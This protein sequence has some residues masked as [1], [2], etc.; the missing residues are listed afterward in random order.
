MRLYVA[1][2]GTGNSSNKIVRNLKGD[3]LF[4]TNSFDGLKRDIEGESGIYDTVYMFGLD[5]NLKGRIR[6]EQCATKNNIS[7]SSELDIEKL[8]VNLNKSG[9]AAEMGNT[10]KESL[11]NTA[12][13]YMLN[14]YYNKVAF[15][16]VPSIKYINEDF[17]SKIKLTL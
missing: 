7:I 17:I 16:H 13:W 2:K 15:F 10:P 14:K 12:Y 9:I 6:V 3:K 1:F 4:L 8:I 11:C 5:K